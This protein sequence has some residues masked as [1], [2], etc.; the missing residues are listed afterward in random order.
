M[1]DLI[2]SAIVLG[3]VFNAMPGAIFAESVRRGLQ[4]GFRPAF[5]VQ[6][7]SLLGDLT[8]A[9]IGLNGAGALLLIPMVERPLALLGAALLVALAWQSFSAALR[10][11]PVCSGQVPPSRDLHSSAL[12]T[13][14]GLSLTNPVHIGYWAALGGG[15]GVLAGDLEPVIAF[16]TFLAAFMF[17]CV[18]WCFICAAAIAWTRTRLGPLFWVSLNVGCGVG[19]GLFALAV[20]LRTLG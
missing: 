18:L 15:V 9:L 8:W 12:A 5:A 7:G 14:A 11:L 4:G 20:V 10:P 13:G 16:S 3:L 17:T 2:A 19:L 1:L 6:V